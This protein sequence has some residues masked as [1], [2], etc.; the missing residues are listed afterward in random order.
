M[1]KRNDPKSPNIVLAPSPTDKTKILK[2]VCEPE[3][4]RNQIQDKLRGKLGEYCGLIHGNLVEDSKEGY[5]S[6]G[7]NGLLD[8]IALFKGI[9]RP[10]F[11]C[12]S[13]ED[14]YIYILNPTNSYTYQ[15][16]S[17]GPFITEKPKDSVFAVY[18]EMT[19]FFSLFPKEIII[20]LNQQDVCGKIL[21]WE[22][23]KSEDNV[24]PDG[25]GFRY[26]QQIW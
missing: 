26:A 14:I 24:M 21:F 25:H 22:W 11:L 15:Y 5:S 1:L 6:N 18:V 3:T 20:Q 8:A 16:R 12:Y 7:T 17:I 19:R 13:D 23:V 4:L 9:K 10:R 2:L